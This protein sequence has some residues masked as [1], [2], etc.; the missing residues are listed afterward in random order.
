[1]VLKYIQMPLL[2]LS[3][4]FVSVIFMVFMIQL[5]WFFGLHGHNVLAPLMDG[6]YLTALNE[7]IAVYQ[8]TLDVSQTSVPLDER[9]FRCILS[10]GR[11]WYYTWS[12]HCDLCLF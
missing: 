10:D 5:L 3:Q 6:V 9:I 12:N 1:M 8:Q 11:F 7:N 4:G 2:G